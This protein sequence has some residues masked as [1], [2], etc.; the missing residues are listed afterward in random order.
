MQHALN[1]TAAI[2]SNLENHPLTSRTAQV[3]ITIQVAAGIGGQGG[4]GPCAACAGRAVT[5]REAVNHSLRPT[6]PAVRREVVND[7][8]TASAPRIIAATPLCAI[9]VSGGI[10]AYA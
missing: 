9:K 4:D 2:R 6:P 5:A 1:P 8:P 7:A 3:R 10:Q